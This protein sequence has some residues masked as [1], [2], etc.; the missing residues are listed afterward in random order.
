MTTAR[1]GPGAAG[2]IAAVNATP[3]AEVANNVLRLD[4]CPGCAY[5]LEGLPPEGVCPECGRAYDQKTVILYGWAAGSK[6]DPGNARPWHAAA[7]LALPL[8]YCVARGV[9]AWGK[10]QSFRVVFFAALVVAIAWGLWRRFTS[11][12][13]GL[14][15]VRLSDAGCVQADTTK[16]ADEATPTP[17]VKVEQVKLERAGEGAWRLR[18]AGK[19]SRWGGGNA[20]VDAEVNCTDARAAALR[21]RIDAWRKAAAAAP[22]ESTEE[23][24]PHTTSA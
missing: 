12:E 13:P 23:I 8:A 9:R 24:S 17:W 2:I 5:Q 11:F 10:G 7:L 22:A 6:A 3:P 15:Q 19:A 21:E 20:Y 16:E 1:I 4:V 18:L 14:A